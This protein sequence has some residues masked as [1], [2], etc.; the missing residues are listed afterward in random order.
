MTA[1]QQVVLFGSS[2]QAASYVKCFTHDHVAGPLC[3]VVAMIDDYRGGQGHIVNGVPVV[4][5]EHWA[6]NLRDKACFI[7]VGNPKARREIGLRLARAGGS[8]V[9]FYRIANQFPGASAGCGTYLH[10]TVSVMSEVAIGDHVQAM[11][12]TVIGHDV[13]IGSCVTLCSSVTVSGHVVIEDEVFIGAGAV[14]GNGTAA[15]PLVIGRG[16]TVGVGAVVTKSVLPATT[17]M[18]NPARPLRDL[19][20]SRRGG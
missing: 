9:D 14:L 17:V 8:F 1:L 11:P 16:A 4:D 5:F 19:A 7:S 20:R 18:G 2:G 3:E 12:F 13:R 10:P 6:R 15:R